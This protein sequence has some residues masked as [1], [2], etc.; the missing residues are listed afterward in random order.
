MTEE[1]PQITPGELVQFKI[2][3]TSAMDSGGSTLHVAT[4]RFHALAGAEH[5]ATIFDPNDARTHP[6]SLISAVLVFDN[7]KTDHRILPIVSLLPH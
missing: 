4:D 6:I 1:R 2:D 7:E 5:L 3:I